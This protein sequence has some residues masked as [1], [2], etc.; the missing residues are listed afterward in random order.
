MNNVKPH[1]WLLCVLCAA[2]GC[3]RDAPR[4]VTAATTTPAP[5]TPAT[6]PSPRAGIEAF[7]VYCDEHGVTLRPNPDPDSGIEY[8]VS[9]P[10]AQGFNIKVAFQVFPPGTSAATMFNSSS[11]QLAFPFMNEDAGIAM[12]AFEI[13]YETNEQL[14]TDPSELVAA[15]QAQL[16]QLLFDYRLRGFATTQG[17]SAGTGA[18]TRSVEQAGAAAFA[19]Y[20]AQHGLGLAWTGRSDLYAVAPASRDD[21]EL[22][23]RLRAF[24]PGTTWFAAQ[25]L[26]SKEVREYPSYNQAAGVV[27]SDAGMRATHKMPTDAYQRGAAEIA[28]LKALF[29]AYRPP[30]AATQA[31]QPTQPAGSTR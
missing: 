11:S 31:T 29:D 4:Q 18:A 5:A 13:T 22:L 14:P 7:R 1:A 10:L 24:S 8:F 12:S 27:M 16:S 3:T 6:L 15:L 30:Q 9:T 26:L 17:H 20:C 2:P 21:F 19:H 28:N 23:V 25:K